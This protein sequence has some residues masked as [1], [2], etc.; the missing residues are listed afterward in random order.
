MTHLHVACQ[1]DEVNVAL[2][3]RTLNVLLL[4]MQAGHDQ[5]QQA[6]FKMT[7]GSKQGSARLKAAS[8]VQYE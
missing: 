2:L 1:H 4:Q 5:G 6:E 3:Q 8:G 7:E